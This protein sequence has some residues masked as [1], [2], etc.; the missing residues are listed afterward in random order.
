MLIAPQEMQKGFVARSKD[1]VV[2]MHFNDI[3]QGRIT[4]G[5]AIDSKM[6]ENAF[7]AF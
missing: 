3:L 1:Y 4:A 2:I 6:V 7:A 5:Q